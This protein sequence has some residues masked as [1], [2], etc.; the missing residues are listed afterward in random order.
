MVCI[1]D[2]RSGCCESYEMQT[3]S[4]AED[5]AKFVIP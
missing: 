3:A 5:A 1:G 2:A 4:P